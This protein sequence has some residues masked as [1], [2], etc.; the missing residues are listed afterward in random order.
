VEDWG[1]GF[2][3]RRKGMK[4]EEKNGEIKEEKDMRWELLE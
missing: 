3:M 1:M 2:D 4:E